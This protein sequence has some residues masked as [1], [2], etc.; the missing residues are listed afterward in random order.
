MFWWIIDWYKMINTRDDEIK[1]LNLH[2]LELQSKLD[3]IKYILD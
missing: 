1:K 3:S 2:V